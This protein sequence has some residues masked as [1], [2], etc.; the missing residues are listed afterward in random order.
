MIKYCKDK[1]FLAYWFLIQF[2]LHIIFFILNIQY[3]KFKSKVL[4]IDFNFFILCFGLAYNFVMIF[5]SIILYKMN[6]ANYKDEI[7]SLFLSI[8]SEFLFS[9]YFSISISHSFCN[10]ILYIFFVKEKIFDY[11]FKYIIFIIYIHIIYPLFLF[12]DLIFRKRF[13]LKVNNNENII[14]ILVLSIIHFIV[15]IIYFRSVKVI[16]HFIETIFVF[17]FGILLYIFYDYFTFLREEDSDDF[18]Y[19]FYRNKLY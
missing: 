14:V 3:D 16:Y 10:T 15:N 18:V 19:N 9:F 17:I 2:V 11:K 13:L 8:L 4:F 12:L 1:K 6:E 5:D 7:G